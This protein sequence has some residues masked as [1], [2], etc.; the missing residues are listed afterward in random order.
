MEIDP[1]AGEPETPPEQQAGPGVGAPPEDAGAGGAEWPAAGAAAEETQAGGRAQAPRGWTYTDIVVVGVFAVGAQLL[2]YVGGVLALLLF[3]QQGRAARFSFLDAI[4]SVSFIL[5]AQLVWWALMFWIIRRIVRARD[6]RPFRDAIRWVWPAQPAVVYLG[7]GAL[8]ALTVAA[9]SWV[10]PMSKRHVPMEELF[11]DPASAF[12]LAAFGVL[13]APPVEELLFRGFLYPVVERS[14]GV[15]AAV[16]ATAALFSLLH[17]Q[18]YGWAWQNLLLLGYVG[19]VFGAARAKSGS[20]VP[21]TLMHAGYNLTLFVGLY[22]SS[23]R[24][25]NFNF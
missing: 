15:V 18:Q 1:S 7:G 22:A 10:L 2:V 23:N 5:P 20:L 13:I 25:R 14:H 16:V 11:K 24:F 3:A 6:P 8:L 17:A 19:V 4:S 9:L 21:S 12:L